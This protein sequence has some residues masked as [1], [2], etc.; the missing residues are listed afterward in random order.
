MTNGLGAA[1]RREAERLALLEHLDAARPEADTVLQG[2]VDDVR[3]V[4]GTDLALVNLVLPEEQYFRAWSGDLPE[5]FTRAR[6]APRE[7]SVCARVVETGEPLVVED[8]L[9][10]EGLRNQYFRV[11]HG[12]RFYAGVPLVASNGI[13]IG[14]MCLAGGAPMHFGEDR[15]ELLGAFAR[16]A[17]GRIELLGSLAR[18]GRQRELHETL[19]D[20]Q[21]EVGEGLVLT[22]GERIVHANEAFERIG[23]YDAREL[24]AMPS[25]F[26]LVPPEV[27]AELGE[28]LRGRLQNKPIEDHVETTIVHKSG[29]LVS[30]EVGVKVL[31]ADD[32]ARLV[33]VVRDVTDRKRSEEKVRFQA[34]LLDTVGQAVIAIDLSDAVVYWNRAAEALYGWSA[35]EAVGRQIGE[36]LIS[37]ETKEQTQEIMV[38]LRAGESWA[39]EF[40]VRRRDGSRLPVFVHD[41]PVRDDRG[42]LVGIIGVSSDITERKEAEERLREAETRYRSLVERVPAVIYV[43]TLVPG[44]VAVY[45]VNY[46]S[47]R[48]EDLLG[49]PP[50]RFTDDP[51]LWNALIHPDDSASALAEMERTDE[52]GEPFDAEYRMF[53]RDGRVVWVRDEAALIH[54]AGGRPMYWQG[55][56]TDITERKSTEERLRAAHRRHQEMVDAAEAI[57][58]RA[59]AKTFRFTF[60][61]HQAEAILGYPAERWTA[62]PSFWPDHIHPKDREWALSF[63]RAATAEKRSH[64]FEYRMLSADGGVVWLRDSVHVVVED[65]VP[66]Q[67]IGVMTD[68]TERKVLEE[69]LRHRAFHDSLTGLPNRALLVD[70][71]EHALA[72]SGREEGDPAVAVLFMDLDNFKIVNDSLGHGAGDGLLV[73][74]A[75]RLLGCL[76]PGDTAARLG[77]DEF[78]VLLEGVADEAEAVRVAERIG[79]ALR[80]PFSLGTHEAHVDASIGVALGSPSRFRAGLL[81]AEDLVRNADIA[82]YQAKVGGRARLRLFE[83]DMNARATSRL[84]AENRFRKAIDRKELVTY[85]QP[86]VSVGS[87]EVVGMEALVR[88]ADPERGV[89]SPAEFIPLAEETGLVVPMGELVMR[90]ACRQAVAWRR[91]RSPAD[92]I[93]VWVNLS[94]RQFHRSDIVERVSVVLGETGLDP[95]CLGLEITERVVMDD[96]ESTI[97]TLRRLRAMGV[98]LA[99]DDFGKGYSSLNYVKRFPVDCLK[100]DRSFVGGIHVHPEDLAIVQAVTTLGRALGMEVVAEGVE[101]AGQLEMLRGLGCDQGQGYHFARPMPA[102]EAAAFLAAHGGGPR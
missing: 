10:R 98:R 4:F 35:K 60:V 84:D 49:Y 54:D 36:M 23:G 1:D 19:L 39:G 53:H 20:A 6:R 37:G 95:G 7:H 61:S 42:D 62:E 75:E 33:I 9:D 86:K 31:K 71:I 101:T 26:A 2:I 80:K 74:T 25:F 55:I 3:R 94:P 59:D 96:A 70:R 67:L 81:R 16:A 22:E 102:G 44:E 41:T 63:C 69:Q 87:G 65:G 30:A 85:Y 82:M 17:V 15:L 12:T 38:R 66:T 77:G 29:R 48:V 90:E 73:E 14:T 28:R 50:E 88:W 58:W 21:S 100:I 13:A 57:I 24:A 56:L 8:F 78:A 93:A 34:R 46:I 89:V 32:P 68:I 5:E 40:V 51:K 43:E 64:T 76:R 97:E 83:P 99:I 47:P 45:N 18:E 79:G 91:T 72:G 11:N 27:R 52:T 92:P